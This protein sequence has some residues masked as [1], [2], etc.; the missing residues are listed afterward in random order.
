MVGGWGANRIQICVSALTRLCERLA[1]I[2]N[3]PVEA[4]ADNGH[5]TDRNDNG[6]L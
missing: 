6:A 1:L 3:Y 5:N 2:F 4:A